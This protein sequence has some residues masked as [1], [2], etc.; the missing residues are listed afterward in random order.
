MFSV[1]IHISINLSESL[2]LCVGKPKGY[3]NFSAEIFFIF[4]MNNRKVLK[5]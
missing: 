2:C 4:H 3:E 1:S 5:K